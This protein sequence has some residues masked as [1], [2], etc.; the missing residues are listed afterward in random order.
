MG[1]PSRLP[2]ESFVFWVDEACILEAK[3]ARVVE[4]VASWLCILWARMFITPKL[5]SLILD[6]HI[7]APRGVE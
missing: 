6:E 2:A 3:K 1:Y 5:L 4:R 7:Y